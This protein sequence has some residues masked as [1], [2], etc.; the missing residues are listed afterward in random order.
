DA[1][2]S[3]EQLTALSHRVNDRGCS[4]HADFALW[5]PFARLGAR[6]VK[7]RAWYPTG[8]GSFAAE[9]LP[10]PGN[11]QHWEAAWQVFASACIVFMAAA[12]SAL[13]RYA[14]K[15][16]KLVQ[17]WPDCWHLIATADDQMR[18]E[19]MV[20]LKRRYEAKL[21]AG[22]TPAP[23]WNSAAPWST[24]RRLAADDEAFW[25]AHV[26]HP[27]AAWVPRGGRGVLLAP[28]G[29]VAMA[30]LPGG[31]AA[32]APPTEQRPAA[33]KR[34]K[35][36]TQ[37]QRP[38][39]AC[40]IWDQ[41]NPANERGKLGTPALDLPEGPGPQVRQVR[42]YLAQGAGLPAPLTPAPGSPG[43]VAEAPD[44]ALVRVGQRGN[45]LVRRPT[46][47]AAAAGQPAAQPALAEVTRPAPTAAAPDSRQERREQEN[48][49]CVGGLRSTAASVARLPRLC[50]LGK[51][52]AALCDDWVSEYPEATTCGAA[53]R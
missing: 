8:D 21:A 23:D 26:R 45:A 50:A 38:Q 41:G 53:F 30:D 4:P 28:E 18:A 16:R 46:S 52:V 22:Q 25:G 3:A 20:R 10:G 15:I 33:G 17:L 36:G 51:E 48:H 31:L 32:I 40:K 29:A 1:E 7:F 49:L 47:A 24:A 34:R 5:G 43:A 11:L 35:T 12:R 37:Q 39:Q 14:E 42:R 9:E 2:P 19:H 13:E 27:A 6:A 44:S